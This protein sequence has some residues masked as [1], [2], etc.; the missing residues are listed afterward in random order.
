MVRFASIVLLTLAAMTVCAQTY[1]SR[2]VTMIVP[3]PPGGLIDLV[4]RINQALN[5]VTADPQIRERLIG[6]GATV[7][8]GSPE[9]FFAFVKAEIEKWGPVAKRAGVTVD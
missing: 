9:D 7:I 8:Q 5:R 1:P 6:R 2:P 4:A 3:Y